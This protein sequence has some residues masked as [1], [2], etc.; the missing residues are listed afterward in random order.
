MDADQV[1]NGLAEAREASATPHGTGAT[2]DEVFAAIEALTPGELLKLKYFAAWRIR[3][4]GRAC[5]GRT[6]EDL[7]SE[8]KLSTLRG[9]A[10][11]PGRCWNKNVDL[12]TH[13]AGA[14][15]SISSHWKR[16]FDE[17]EAVLE[18]EIVTCSEE[19]DSTSPLNNAVSEY[20][21][22]EREVAA[23]QEWDLIAILCHDDPAATQV[24]EGFSRGMSATEIMR[25]CDLTKWEY[26]QALKRIRHVA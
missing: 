14:I 9:A 4:L 24:L 8:A 1:P 26:Q 5:C 19:E 12:V 2:K 22:Q 11:H 23:R 15:R 17:Q 3:G 6:W 18:S 7:L 16:D 10:S 13:L 21:S 20:P 25:G